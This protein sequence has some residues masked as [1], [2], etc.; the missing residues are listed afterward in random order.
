MFL[1][2]LTSPVE[3]KYGGTLSLEEQARC[4]R[5]TELHS[6]R[7][8]PY[9]KR[10]SRVE[11]VCGKFVVRVDVSPVTGPGPATAERTSSASG[12]EGL[13]S[14]ALI[15]NS[16]C[17]IKYVSCL[18]GQFMDPRLNSVCFRT[19]SPFGRQFELFHVAGHVTVRCTPGLP[20]SVIF[21]GV[22]GTAGTR[23][24]ARDLFLDQGTVLPLV[25]MGVVSSCLG[26]RLQTSQCCYLENRVSAAVGTMQG[27]WIQ[28][29]PRSMD[30]CNI[31]RLTVHHWRGL[32]PEHL[33]PL[34]NDIVITSKGS[35][36]HRLAW[37][38]VPWTDEN[39]RI[40]LGVCAHVAEAISAVC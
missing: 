4:T 26:A 12:E 10:P 20:R 28:V 38:G 3:H 35:V 21:K 31:V 24:L 30:Q 18:S 29:Q 39:E 11:N 2:E 8:N 15:P 25:H 40:V 13:D 17:K 19:D 6:P 23:E 5:Q 22:K 36:M 33:T 37:A 27:G 1:Y 9:P 16:D 34:S 32:L 14:A 7:W